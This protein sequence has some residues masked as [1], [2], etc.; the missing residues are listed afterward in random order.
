MEILNPESLRDKKRYGLFNEKGGLVTTMTGDGIAVVEG[1]DGS[2]S[3]MIEVTGSDGEYKALGLLA[4]G[5]F[6]MEIE[7]AP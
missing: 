1:Y 3:H 5:W 6:I 2:V 7:R 4:P